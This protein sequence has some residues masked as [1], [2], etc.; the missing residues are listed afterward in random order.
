[1]E[2]NKSRRDRIGIEETQEELKWI[3]TKSGRIEMDFNKIW[4]D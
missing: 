1:M 4:R 3:L 2:L